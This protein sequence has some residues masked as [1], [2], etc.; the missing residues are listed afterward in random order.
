MEGNYPFDMPSTTKNS[1]LKDRANL[2]GM[3]VAVEDGGCQGYLYELARIPNVPDYD[4][5]KCHP[6]YWSELPKAQCHRLVFDLVHNN[7]PFIYICGGNGGLCKWD[8]LAT[9]PPPIRWMPHD[10]PHVWSQ[11]VW[12]K[13]HH[14][15]VTCFS[16]GWGDQIVV[17]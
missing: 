1:V 11:E 5:T 8:Y 7:H 17:H 12:S 6:R 10:L 9:V 2:A 3:F 4:F 16:D 13:M 15:I 14:Q